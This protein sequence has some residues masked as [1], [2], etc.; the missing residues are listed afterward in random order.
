MKL[1]KFNNIYNLLQ[2]PKIR[3]LILFPPLFFIIIGALLGIISVIFRF[4]LN[5]YICSIYLFFVDYLCIG[6]LVILY[7]DFKLIKKTI[8]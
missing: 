4:K 8:L 7:S 2:K 6:L 1:Y 3:C 5:T